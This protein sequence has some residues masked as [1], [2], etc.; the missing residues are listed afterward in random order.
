MRRPTQR[1][2]VRHLSLSAALGLAIAALPGAS[3]PTADAVLLATGDGERNVEIPPDVPEL[4]RV[5]DRS[6]FGAIF[7][8][9]GW[10]LTARHVSAGPVRIG[11]ETFDPIPGSLRE[12]RN[13]DGTQADLLLFRI[14][15]AAALGLPT[16]EPLSIAKGSPAPGDFVYLMGG[17]AN[18]GAPLHW[19]LGVLGVRRGW[20]WGSGGALRW[21]TN[22]IAG[23]RTHVAMGTFRSRGFTMVFG[24]PGGSNTTDD[25]AMVAKGDSGGA[26]LMRRDDRWVLCGVLVARTTHPGQPEATAAYGNRILAV[27]LSH[28]RE[29]ILEVI[30]QPFRPAP[31]SPDDEQAPEAE[32]KRE[33]QASSSGVGT[34]APSPASAKLLP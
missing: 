21:G 15:P 13:E 27:D 20:Q 7:L 32:A 4:G 28:Y 12:F 34:L 23:L 25:E 33:A 30:S 19:S 14:D 6:G 22:R 2:R 10:I 24:E 31:L 9:D 16:Q 3:V 1:A 8:E 11:G 29:Q 5:V 17:G 18:R 26:V